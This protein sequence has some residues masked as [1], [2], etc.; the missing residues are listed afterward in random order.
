MVLLN[1]EITYEARHQQTAVQ[2]LNYLLDLAE[3]HRTRFLLPGVN[4][5]DAK[6]EVVTGSAWDDVTA[7]AQAERGFT[8]VTVDDVFVFIPFDSLAATTPALTI[9]DNPSDTYRYSQIDEQTGTELLY[10]KVVITSGDPTPVEM[11]AADLDSIGRWGVRSLA[12]TLPLSAIYAQALAN[13]LRDTY[14]TMRTR[15]RSIVIHPARLAL[16]D[17]QALM[18]LDIGSVITVKRTPLGTGS[19]ATIQQDVVIIGIADQADAN[20][21]YTITFTLQWRS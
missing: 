21:D 19:P 10:N 17:R 16:V 12:M 1:H 7:I 11:V 4:P 3:Y 18:R 2:R 5:Y 8:F 9:S 15:F 20:G 6:T 14:G 13:E